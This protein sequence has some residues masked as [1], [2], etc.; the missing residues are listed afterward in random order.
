MKKCDLDAILLHVNWYMHMEQ[1]T[2]PNSKHHAATG[3]GMSD[4]LSFCENP[5]FLAASR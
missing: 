3:G 4:F 5:L 1:E 2:T